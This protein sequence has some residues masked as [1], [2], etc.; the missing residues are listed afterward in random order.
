MAYPTDIVATGD[1]IT[2][3]QIN[4]WQVLL[5]DTLV[6]GSAAASIDF[7]S[8]PAHWT[9]L[10]VKVDGRSSGAV[11]ADY[12]RMRF[13]G[14]SGSNYNYQQLA[15]VNAAITAG[16]GVGV[17][18]IIVLPIAGSSASASVSGGGVVEVPSYAGTT[19]HKSVHAHGSV[20]G[21]DAAGT[22]EV[23]VFGGRWRSSSAI[24][25]ITLTLNSGGNFE[26]G[27]RASVYGC[28][29]I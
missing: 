15:A 13:N 21:T 29:R 5:A 17:T 18:G 25:Q 1:L 16:P 24:N 26:V 22:Q 8:I 23:D 10:I 27:S 2:A 28:G 11:V 19:W 6:T 14:D 4:R 3:A 12:V 7:T 9:H 20:S